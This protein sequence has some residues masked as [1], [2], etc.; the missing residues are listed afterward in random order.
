MLYSDEVSKLRSF[1][2]FVGFEAARSVDLL[3][4]I[5][6]TI[7]ACEQQRRMMEQFTG[8][9]GEFVQSLKRTDHAIDEDGSVLAALEAARDAI[10]QVYAQHKRKRE[11]AAGDHRLCEDDGVVD[12]YDQ[13]LD[14]IA[15]AHTA[16]ND[17]CWALG[18]HEADFDKVL[19]GEFST[20]EELIEALEK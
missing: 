18:E 2:Q 11:A 19:E 5:D 17:L 12:A 7:Y 4:A 6:D 16:L 9:A 10:H 1:G 3:K 20:A 15:S 14:G 8:A 13:L